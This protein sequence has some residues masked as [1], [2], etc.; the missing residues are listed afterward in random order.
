MIFSLMLSSILFSKE[1]S[2]A[3]SLSGDMELCVE[4]IKDIF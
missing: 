2:R 1:T 3:D 4:K